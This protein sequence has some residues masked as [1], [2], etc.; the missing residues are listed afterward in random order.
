M[1]TKFTP[2]CISNDDETSVWT[3]VALVW[4]LKCIFDSLAIR[5]SGMESLELPLRGS[6]I[7]QSSISHGVSNRMAKGWIDNC[8]SLLFVI[9]VFLFHSKSKVRN[10]KETQL[11]RG[12]APPETSPTICWAPWCSSRNGCDKYRKNNEKCLRDGKPV[13][14][15]GQK[16]VQAPLGL[17]R[18]RPG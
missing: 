16:V 18:R 14:L 10:M 2:F 9:F 8:P 4:V 17:G 6:R 15:L 13:F 1:F 11:T 3:T 5:T 7:L 12:W